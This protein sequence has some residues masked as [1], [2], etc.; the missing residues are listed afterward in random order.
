MNRVVFASLLEDRKMAS[1]LCGAA[2]LH[3]GCTAAGFAGWPC[4]LVSAT[5]VPCPGCGLA[6]AAVALLQG[7]IANA[8]ALHA[9]APVVP[10]AISLLLGAL[11]LGSSARTRLIGAIRRIELR[12]GVTIWLLFG[13]LIYWVARLAMDRIAP[14][15]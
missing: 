1:V 9:F 11:V 3:I 13:L 7:E 4:P 5:G 8:F 12:T 14:L 2:A 15:I 6:R 10:I